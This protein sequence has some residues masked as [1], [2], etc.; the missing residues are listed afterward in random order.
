MGR[1]VTPDVWYG[2]ED[3]AAMCSSRLHGRISVGGAGVHLRGLV[4]DGQWN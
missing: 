4:L 1:C 2:L 3:F